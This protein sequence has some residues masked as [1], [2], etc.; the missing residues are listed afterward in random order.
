M[1]LLCKTIAAASFLLVFLIKYFFQIRIFRNY[2]LFLF[3][4]RR[5]EQTHAQE[6]GNGVHLSNLYIC[7]HS[8]P[9][10]TTSKSFRKLSGRKHC[11]TIRWFWSDRNGTVPKWNE[12]RLCARVCLRKR[13]MDSL[14]ADLA[15]QAVLGEFV[16]V[17]YFSETRT[18]FPICFAT[19]IV[20]RKYL[21]RLVAA[22]LVLFCFVSFLSLLIFTC[23]IFSLE[24]G[25]V[26]WV[27]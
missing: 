15:L 24:G 3:V 5:R 23:T 13:R 19:Q 8:Q 20:S 26:F 2:F 7:N 14:S 10:L 4:T 1:K 6:S 9:I 22:L 12:H 18:D 11:A 25:V 17:T 16:K 27:Y 21:R